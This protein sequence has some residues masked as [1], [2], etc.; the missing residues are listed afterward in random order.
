MENNHLTSCSM[1]CYT[2]AGKFC[3]TST[4]TINM[5]QVSNKQ[6]FC[7]GRDCVLYGHALRHHTAHTGSHSIPLKTTGHEK[8]HF[9]VILTAKANG[10]K[11]K[12]FVIFKG[13]GTCLVKTLQQSPVVVVK[14][15]SNG[16]MNDILTIEYLCT[17][18]LAPF[19][20]PSVYL[21]GMLSIATL[22]CQFENSKKWLNC[23]STLLLYQEGAGNLFRL[24]M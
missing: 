13:K 7:H 21:F 6:H 14:F 23:G 15:S 5:S 17:Q 16:W 22:V 8:D 1:W 24:L 10:T 4:V 3:A 12:P 9:T 20:S 11:L 2:K 18:F 19:H